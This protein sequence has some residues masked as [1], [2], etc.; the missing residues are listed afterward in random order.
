MAITKVAAGSPANGVLEVGDVL[1]GVAGKPFSHDPRQELGK[2]LTAAEAS[3]GKLALTRW[4]AGKTEEIT[5]KLPVLGS[6]SPTAPYDCPKS[7]R[8]S[9]RS[10]EA[11]AEADGG[12][13]LQGQNA[14]TRSLN[15]LGLLASGDPKYHPL[16]KKEAEWAA[17]QHIEHMATWWY[18]YL[19]VFLSEY[20]MATGDDSVL[21]GLRRIAM[22]AAKGQSAVGSW[23]H[24]FANDRGPASRLRHD[25]LAGGGADP[26]HGAGARGGRR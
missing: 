13:G 4:R 15:A 9:R 24:K 1:L 20:V 19:T 26:G 23:G 3:D 16:I 18:G 10:C 8:S 22:E 2:A 5:L 21:P 14:I 6:Y 12:T 7:K 17:D 25:E 11:L